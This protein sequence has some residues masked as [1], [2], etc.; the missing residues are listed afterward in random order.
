MRFTCVCNESNSF[1]VS[2]S[3]SCCCWWSFF[4][5]S[6]RVRFRSSSPWLLWARISRTSLSSFWLT[7]WSSTT[8][9][10]TEKTKIVEEQLRSQVDLPEC[11]WNLLVWIIVGRSFTV[12]WTFTCTK[13]FDFCQKNLNLQNEHSFQP[14]EQIHPWVTNEPSSPAIYYRWSRTDSHVE[15]NDSSRYFHQTFDV[16]PIIPGGKTINTKDRLGIALLFSLRSTRWSIWQSLRMTLRNLVS[17][18]EEWAQLL[19]SSVRTRR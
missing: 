11:Q 8:L 19:W 6:N 3:F 2:L 18:V 7:C 16:V 10:N 14:C 17:V 9:L 15:C 13:L 4:S 1:L 12:G 5:S